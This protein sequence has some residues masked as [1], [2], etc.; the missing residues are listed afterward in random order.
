[1][2]RARLPLLAAALVLPGLLAVP[3]AHGA[4]LCVFESN[5]YSEGARIC[6]EPGLLMTCS[7]SGDRALWIVATDKDLTGVCA[8]SPR[9]GA[10]R[11]ER[12]KAGRRAGAEPS[13]SSAESTPKCFT[14]AGKRY[15]E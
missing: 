7:V 3:Q 6:T 5:S 1:M 11:M 12:R 14:F 10:S 9:R 2:S 13:P 4:G 15:C 8:G